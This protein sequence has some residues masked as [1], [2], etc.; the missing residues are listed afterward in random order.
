MTHPFAAAVIP[1]LL[2]DNAGAHPGTFLVSM[3]EELK[4]EH[5][6]T[7]NNDLYNFF[8]TDGV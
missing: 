4:T 5:W 1:Q 8:Q 7:K 2:A 6:N 3:M